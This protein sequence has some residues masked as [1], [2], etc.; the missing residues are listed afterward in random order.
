MLEFHCNGFRGV[1]PRGVVFFWVIMTG[2]VTVLGKSTFTASLVQDLKP[3][4][5][6]KIQGNENLHRFGLRP[7]LH[8]VGSRVTVCWYC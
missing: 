7:V 4:K 2:G 1:M 6:T 5:G 3:S 8:H